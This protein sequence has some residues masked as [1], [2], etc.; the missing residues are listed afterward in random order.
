MIGSDTFEL[1]IKKEDILEDGSFN[2]ERI[3]RP[4]VAEL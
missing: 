2:M 1:E 3:A 4:I